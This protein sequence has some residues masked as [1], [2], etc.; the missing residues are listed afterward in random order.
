MLGKSIRIVMFRIQELKALLDK[1]NVQK[2]CYDDYD[3]LKEL[4]RFNKDLLISLTAPQISR[5]YV[6]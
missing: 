5:K 1:S 6:Q 2:N 3:D 4:L